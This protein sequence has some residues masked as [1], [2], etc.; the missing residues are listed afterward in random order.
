[1]IHI[2]GTAAARFANAALS[3]S[4]SQTQAV[5]AGPTYVPNLETDG[6]LSDI[7]PRLATTPITNQKISPSGWISADPISFAP[8]VLDVECRHL[9]ISI[10][11]SNRLIFYVDFAPVPPSPTPRPFSL[12][13]SSNAPGWCRL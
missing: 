9:V 7:G 8:F 12:L 2:Y 11:G 1:M 13:F 3:W 10:V 4:T 6:F 5:L